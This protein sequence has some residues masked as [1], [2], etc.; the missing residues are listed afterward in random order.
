MVIGAAYAGATES[1]RRILKYAGAGTTPPSACHV[2]YGT[3][4]AEKSASRTLNNGIHWGLGWAYTTY[5]TSSYLTTGDTMFAQNLGLGGTGNDGVVGHYADVV[6]GGSAPSYLA[7]TYLSKEY[8]FVGGAPGSQGYLAWRLGGV[9]PIATTSITVGVKRSAV[10]SATKVRVTIT[11][12]SGA[13]ATN[14][15]SADSCTVTGLD[16]RQGSTALMRLEYLSA[17]D[18]VL[19]S[20]D[21]QF[22]PMV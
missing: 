11:Q 22:V 7:Q 3:G 12:P 14:T 10:T 20:G 4:D 9:A 2:S 5:G 8:A 1:G 17:G 21:Q 16:T 18:V 6:S 19:A 15:C 13:T